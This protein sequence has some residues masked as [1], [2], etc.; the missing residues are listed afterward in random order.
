LPYQSAFLPNESPLTNLGEIKLK[1]MSRELFE[2]VIKAVRDP[3]A[4]KGDTIEYNANA[5][6]VGPNATVEDLL[7]KLPGVSV[8]QDGSIKAQGQSVQKVTVDGKTFF[9]NDPKIATKNI[10]A[11]AINK[12]QIFNDKSEQAKFS[13]VDDGKKEKTINLELKDTFKN[14]GFGRFTLGQGLDDRREFRATYSKFSKTE[15]FSIIGLANNTNQEGFS[16]NDYRDF[17]GSQA[18]SNNSDEFGFS[19]G[20]SYFFDSGNNAGVPI[21][22]QQGRGFSSS[23]AGGVNYNFDQK[24]TKLTSSY[25]F[26]QTQRIEQ[27]FTN[28]KTFLQN[29]TFFENK[30]NANA[31]NLAANHRINLRYEQGLDSLNTLLATANGSYQI[32]DVKM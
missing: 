18:F 12:I 10:P 9:S 27:T 26:N 23:Y 30:D 6:K 1:P 8:E 31:N 15:Q 19:A 16:F 14:G 28:K 21:S 3:I 20:N 25:F 29:N 11:E 2:V 4:I 13:G 24:K 32:G 7:R 17:A 22:S 5:F